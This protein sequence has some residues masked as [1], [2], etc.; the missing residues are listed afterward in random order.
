MSDS[1]KKLQ[2]KIINFREER[3]WKQFH[4]PKDL[5]ISV[6]IEAAELLE[7]F[8]WKDEKA[9]KEYLDSDKSSE[10]DEEM[11]DILIYLIGLSDVLGVDLIKAANR[12]LD[13]NAK[14]Y[15]AEKSKGSAKKYTE[16]K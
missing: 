7:C 5:A 6:S 8:Q 14:K 12:K 9:V 2:A 16:Y 1:I 13:K 4:T 11:A 10:I 15:P 3:D